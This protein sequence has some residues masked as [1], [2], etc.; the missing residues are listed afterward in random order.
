M[1]R[2]VYPLAVAVVAAS[3]ALFVVSFPATYRGFLEPCDVDPDLT[4]E[5][6]VEQCE[7]WG[8]TAAQHI[9]LESH[10]ISSSSYALLAMLREVLIV[11]PYVAVGLVLLLRRRDDWFAAFTAAV[12]VSFGMTS[13]GSAVFQLIEAGVPPWVELGART[14]QFIGGAGLLLVLWLFPTGTVV[15]KWTAWLAPLWILYEF[16]EYMLPQVFLIPEGALTDNLFIVMVLTGVIAQVYRYRKA[17][18]PVQ[19]QQTKWVVSA[20]AVGLT[21]FALLIFGVESVPGE[22]AGGLVTA[23]VGESLVALALA[24]IPLSIAVAILRYRLWD[25]DVILRRTITYALVIALVVGVYVAGVLWLP[26][27]LGTQSELIVAV[28][29]L[30]VA[31]LF[32]PVRRRVHAFIDRRFDR[33]HYDAAR[34][35]ER[36]S[37]RLRQ[38]LDLGGLAADLTG[39]VTTTLRPAALFLWLRGD[40]P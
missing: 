24:V 28:S 29:T 10:G 31:A 2:F 22:I 20:V 8:L 36:L 30:A 6:G 1:R 27:L 37:A 4:S 17:S 18:D 32:N 33:T 39:V 13:F 3:V 14:L 15:P 5:Q 40:K 26:L 34:V 16:D 12:L 7:N 35:V 21:V 25:I 23:V 11:L 19:R 9:E 38:D